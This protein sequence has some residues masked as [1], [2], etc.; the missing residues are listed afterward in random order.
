M[1]YKFHFASKFRLHNE[2]YPQFFRV[3]DRF[4]IVWCADKSVACIH[5]SH[6]DLLKY[7]L[8]YRGVTF[9]NIQYTQQILNDN[10]VNTLTST[11]IYIER[12]TR[13]ML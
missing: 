7:K 11:N 13:P 8:Y 6:D 5:R 4:C 9:L 1:L 12:A 2:S 10:S 3:F